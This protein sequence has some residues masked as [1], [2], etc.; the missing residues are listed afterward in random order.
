MRK[1]LEMVEVTRSG[2]K[3]LE[4]GVDCYMRV[5]RA[6]AFGFWS[7]W[8]AEMQD[9]VLAIME[10]HA[11]TEAKLQGKCLSKW[12]GQTRGKNRVRDDVQACIEHHTEKTMGG[13]FDKW[14]TYTR[15]K[16]VFLAKKAVRLANEVGGIRST[17]PVPPPRSLEDVRREADDGYLDLKNAR[18]DASRGGVERPSPESERKA[19]PS[20]ERYREESQYSA[21]KE[22][23]LLHKEKAISAEMEWI[24]VHNGEHLLTLTLTL[25]VTLALI[26]GHGGECTRQ[27]FP[28]Q[29]WQGIGSGAISG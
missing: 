1:W 26:Q 21:A 15:K 12:L 3:R 29:V 25:I 19:E 27:R 20:R 11:H 17:V 4:D 8:Q 18:R 2:L 5:K 13:L 24:K 9:R 22:A 16:L 23:W 10:G 6:R 7:R 28:L 14:V